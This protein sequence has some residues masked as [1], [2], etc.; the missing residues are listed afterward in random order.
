[1]A[2]S[3][4]FFCSGRLVASLIPTGCLL[5]GVVVVLPDLSCLPMCSVERRVP[6][7]F[8]YDTGDGAPMIATDDCVAMGYT[9]DDSTPR[10][11]AGDRTYFLV[12]DWATGLQR[13]RLAD[14]ACKDSSY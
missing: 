12:D 2:E 13:F 5:F 9:C 4:R 10:V 1:M 11:S 14:S 7:L 8:K 3:N 6:S